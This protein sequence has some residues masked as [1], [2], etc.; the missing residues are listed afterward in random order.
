MNGQARTI[1][2]LVFLVAS[3]TLGAFVLMAL[4]RDNISAGPFS[5]SS[6]TRLNS[7]EQIAVG[8]LRGTESRWNRIEVFYSN[9]SSGNLEEIARLEGVNNSQDLN[10]HLVVFNGEGG[11]DGQIAAT[12]KWKHQLASIPSMTWVG[13]SG[14]IRICVISDGISQYPTGSQIQR[15]TGLVDALSR[16]CQIPANQIRYPANWQF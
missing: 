3:M 4:D 5:L 11:Q 14:T 6:Y 16:T 12:N 13:S 7:I 1:K 15:T 10:F 9:T 8:P 2:V